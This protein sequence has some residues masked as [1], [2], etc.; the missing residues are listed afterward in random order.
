MSAISYPEYRQR[1]GRDR[2]YLLSVAAA[3]T[4]DSLTL[5]GQ[6]EHVEDV[7]ADYLLA[8][9]SLRAERDAHQATTLQLEAAELQLEVEQVEVMRLQGL[10]D[11]QAREL[12]ELRSKQL[13]A[14]FRSAA[15]AITGVG[16]EQLAAELAEDTVVEDVSALARGAA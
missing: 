1:G 15:P 6:R 9:S 2:E 8:E 16:Y 14:A 11:A 4:I 10:V 5:C 12:G 3:G 7:C 13:D